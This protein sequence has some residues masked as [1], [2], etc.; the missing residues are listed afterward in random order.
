[1]IDFTYSLWVVVHGSSV[2]LV[3]TGFDA[4][5]AARRGIHL[6]RTSLE[7]LHELGMV[8][9]DVSAIVLSHVHFDHA[10]GLSQFSEVPVFVQEADLD[11]YTGDFMRFALCASAVEKADMAELQQIRDDGRLVLLSGDSEIEEGIKV[12]HVGGHTPGMQ[13]IEVK[14]AR[15]DI[16]LASDAAHLYVN[17]ENQVPFPVLHDVPTSCVAFERLASLSAGGATVVPGHDGLV[18][19]NFERIGALCRG[20]VA[21]LT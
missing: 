21:R 18:M 13:A 11:F 5:V 20:S 19:H 8:A 4:D 16:V 15:G 2:V 3:D 7:A 1:M 17:L 6:E 10:G 12:H 14:G 9:N